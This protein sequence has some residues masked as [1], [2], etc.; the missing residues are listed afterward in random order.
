MCKEVRSL[1]VEN[2][3][4]RFIHISVMSFEDM[5][6]LLATYSGKR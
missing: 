2:L 5:S 4:L 1:F 6:L 3:G